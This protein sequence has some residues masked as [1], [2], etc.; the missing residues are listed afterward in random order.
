MAS[1]STESLN[2]RQNVAGILRKPHGEVL[3]AERVDVPGAWQF[4]QGGVDKGETLEEAFRREMAEELSLNPGEYRVIEQRG[5]YQYLFGNNLVK[6]GFHGKL[7]HFFLA[8]F[9]VE[10]PTIDVRTAHPEFRAT[11]WIYPHEFR[12][13]WLPEMKRE[14][15]R[16]VMRDFFEVE[17]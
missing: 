14:L 10:N 8:E 2:L 16:Q 4:P 6:K 7:Q 11:R 1:A 17:L 5:P 9:L 15:Y 12:L 13:L 3:I